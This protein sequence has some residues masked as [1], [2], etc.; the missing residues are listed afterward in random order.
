MFG[1]ALAVPCI[2]CTSG[3]LQCSPQD[4]IHHRFHAGEG[5]GPSAA[6]E[7]LE[8]PAAKGARQGLPMHLAAITALLRY[9]RVRWTML[10][11]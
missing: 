1:H 10:K 6:R 3:I 11:L 8:A 4:L 2:S 7:Q 5:S 9:D